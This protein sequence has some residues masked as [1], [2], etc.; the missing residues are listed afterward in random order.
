[1][2]DN[3][4]LFRRSLEDA[5]RDARQWAASAGDNDFT[6]IHADDEGEGEG[7]EGVASVHESDSIGNTTRLIDVM[8]SAPVRAAVAVP[9]R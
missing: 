5:N 8:R 4:Q 1:M 9:G 3:V 6:V 2:V 7:D